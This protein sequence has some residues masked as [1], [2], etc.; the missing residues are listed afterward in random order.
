MTAIALRF[1]GL[2][3]NEVSTAENTQIELDIRV[4][5]KMAIQTVTVDETGCTAQFPLKAR[6][7]TVTYQA[8]WNDRGK[9]INVIYTAITR[10]SDFSSPFVF[11][12]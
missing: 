9:R 6:V 12:L 11:N 5:L 7:I 3:Q 1:N 2:L 10:R 4:T 8:R